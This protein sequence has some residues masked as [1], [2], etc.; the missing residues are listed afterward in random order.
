MSFKG[1]ILIRVVMPIP[2]LLYWSSHGG[3]AALS[4]RGENYA[5]GCPRT[6][7]VALV[8]VL[9]DVCATVSFEIMRAPELE[10]VMG[11]VIEE[12]SCMI[13]GSVGDGI[14]VNACQSN[15]LHEMSQT[16]GKRKLSEKK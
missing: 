15:V 3:H 16:H 13:A 6:D 4:D 2:V 11:T 14:S 5:R 9:V 10:G 8:E 1:G 12:D 7:R